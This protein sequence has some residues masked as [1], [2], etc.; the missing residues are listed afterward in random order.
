MARYTAEER[1]QIARGEFFTDAELAARPRLGASIRADAAAAAGSHRDPNS[2]PPSRAAVEM[3][4]SEGV[5]AYCH[6]T[7]DER[8]HLT[9]FQVGG[10]PTLMHPECQSVRSAEKE[11]G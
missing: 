1:R 4:A 7:S 5:C 10:V 8:S 9:P 2:A 6:E 11:A 3:A